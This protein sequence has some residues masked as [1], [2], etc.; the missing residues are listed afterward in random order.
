MAISSFFQGKAQ[1]ILGGIMVVLT[2]GFLGGVAWVWNAGWNSQFG[3]PE[4][5]RRTALPVWFA[6]TFVTLVTAMVFVAFCIFFVYMKHRGEAKAREIKALEDA[7]DRLRERTE[8][9]SLV[10]FNRVLLDR[11]HGIATQQAD[12]AFTSS[13]V[14]MT[15][16]LLIIGVCF[17]ASFQYNSQGDRLFIGSV[18]VVSSAFTGYLSKTYMHVYERALQQL[19]QYF[20][21]PVLNGY[22]LSAERIVQ[23]L[24]KERQA[25]VLE[26]IVDDILES[27]KEMHRHALNATRVPKQQ[28][29]RHASPDATNSGQAPQQP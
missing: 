23:S 11:Y 18:T 25:I 15:V 6:P 28:R 8:L 26:R 17:V 29:R 27:G 14:A 2:V 1:L 16:G 24:P 13:L 22:F 20:D 9:P 4:D 19:N 5:K 3:S 7:A 10:N 12:K 21:Q